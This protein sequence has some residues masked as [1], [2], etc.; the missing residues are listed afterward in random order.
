M[1]RWRMC[2]GGITD[3]KQT[4]GWGVGGMS[5]TFCHLVHVIVRSFL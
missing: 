5:T 2:V 1:T 3:Q 4:E